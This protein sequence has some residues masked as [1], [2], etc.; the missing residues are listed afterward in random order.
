MCISKK[1]LAVLLIILMF[2]LTFANG[3]TVWVMCQPD[4]YVNIRSKPS[5]R[6]RIEGY[7]LCGYD[8]ETDG[9]V[10]NGFLHVYTSVEA[11][12]GWV[13]KG[14]VVKDKPVEVNQL[15]YVCSGSRVAARKTIG[16]ERMK[17][18]YNG[19][20]LMVYWANDEWAVTNRGFVKTKFVEVDVAYGE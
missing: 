2:S 15:H 18:C 9:K 6:S 1:M 16:G 13:A 14:Y 19:D 17:W 20:T 7:A 8:L 11:G 3:E 5:G 4:S 10:K 12:E